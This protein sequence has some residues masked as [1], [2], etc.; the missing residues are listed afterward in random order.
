M[1]TKRK[2]LEM[3][4]TFTDL[5]IDVAHEYLRHGETS[6]ATTVLKD[7]AKASR[8]DPAPVLALAAIYLRQLQKPDF[9]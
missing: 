3:D 4:P 7:A 8:N 1:E 6:E 2:V 9:A 5:S